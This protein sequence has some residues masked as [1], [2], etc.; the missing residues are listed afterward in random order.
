[1]SQYGWVPQV[2]LIYDTPIC[3]DRFAVHRHLANANE[4]HATIHHDCNHL[5]VPIQKQFIYVCSG[6]SCASPSLQYHLKYDGCYQLDGA[7]SQSFTQHVPQI[8]NQCL[9]VVG[10]TFLRF[11]R[12]LQRSFMVEWSTSC[13]TGHHL[14]MPFGAWRVRRAPKNPLPALTQPSVTWLSLLEF[15]Y[16]Y[17]SFPVSAA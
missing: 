8:T 2:S 14:Y 4:W 11:A 7:T 9:T 10:N 13:R 17:P 15:A 3:A 5:H 6:C 1:M 16:G 12:R